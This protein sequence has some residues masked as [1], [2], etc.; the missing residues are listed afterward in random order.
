[1]GGQGDFDECAALPPL[2]GIDG[3]PPLAERLKT[4]QP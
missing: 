4:S 2:P 1:M 3:G